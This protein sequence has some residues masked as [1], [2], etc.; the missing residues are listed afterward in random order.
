MIDK[1][2]KI[3]K[4][5]KYLFLAYDQGLEHG[6]TD[7]NDINVDPN[8][9][10]EIAL[11]G[12]VSAVVLQKGTALKY[13]KGTD[14]EKKVPLVLKINGKSKNWQG[15]TY[16]PQNTSVEF[17][18][19]MGAVAVGY[20][21]YLGSEFEY[22]MFS[23]FGKIVEE[24]HNLGM[25]VIAWVY[26][27]GK[28]IEKDDSPDITAYAARTALELGADMAKIKYCGSAETF[29]WA[30]KSAGKTRVV[31]S[32]GSKTGEDEF[33]G[34]VQSVMDAGGAGVAIGRNIWQAEDPYKIIDGL[35]KIVFK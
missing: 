15:E 33:L 13:W 14:Y 32:G 6:P 11:K 17:A 21:I 29:K 20:T 7:F 28:F 1:L 23:E 5:G 24:A 27:R 26:P 4:D 30:V 18:H 3:S 31:L 22:K 2:E 35:K 25:P 9:I 12:E 16:S 10:L 8:Y 34:V 19:K